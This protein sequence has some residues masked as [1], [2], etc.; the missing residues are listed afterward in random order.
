MIEQHT[1][2]IEFVQARPDAPMFYGAGQHCW[3]QKLVDAVGFPKVRQS[4][5]SSALARPLEGGEKSFARRLFIK[6]GN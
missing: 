4:A 5:P 6:A 1:V 2:L 3:I